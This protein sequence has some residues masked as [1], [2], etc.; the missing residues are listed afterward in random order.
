MINTLI[1][2][3]LACLMCVVVLTACEQ[4]KQAS[5]EVGATPKTVIDKATND[6]AAAQ[7][8]AAQQVKAIENAEEK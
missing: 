2:C 4:Q 7:E 6:I 3:F 1:K 8:L 5:A